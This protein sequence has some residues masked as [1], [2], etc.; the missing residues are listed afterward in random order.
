MPLILKHPALAAGGR[1]AHP[2]GHVDVFATLTALLGTEAAA[3]FEPGVD[4]AALAG[5]APPER[6][7][8]SDLGF[9]LAV[10]LGDHLLLGSVE[11]EPEGDRG[12]D[13]FATLKDYCH[14]LDL[15]FASFGVLT[16]LPGTD[17]MD[18]VQDSLISAIPFPKRL[19]YPEE[20]SAL[21]IHLAENAYI[22]GEVVR[23]D[24]ALRMQPK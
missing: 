8:F 17:L 13:D 6:A 24:G 18:E 11:W 21:A 3:G 2:V 4:L 22:N 20:F 7:L 10:H 15:D 19:G 14:E 9:Q 16:P 12:P 5:G 1:V 23:L